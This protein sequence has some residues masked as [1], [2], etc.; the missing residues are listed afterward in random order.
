MGRNSLA[1][2]RRGKAP[3]GFEEK[4]FDDPEVK[5]GYLNYCRR[6]I[7]HF[8]PDYL[9]IGIEVNELRA[10][11]PERWPHLVELHRYVY[12]ELKKDHPDMQIFATLT[13]HNMLNEQHRNDERYQQDLKEFLKY[14][15]LAGISF[16]SFLGTIGNPERPKEA[17]EWL[18]DF[19]GDKPIAICETG[20]PAEPTDNPM[21]PQ[22]PGSLEAQKSYFET[23]FDY[24]MR[25]NYRF[26]V[27]FLHRDY[28]KMWEKLKE[29]RPA[30]QGAWKDIGLLDG[31]GSARPAWL[32][33]QECLSMELAG[34]EQDLCGVDME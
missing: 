16:Y 27:V 8:N 4:E 15:D 2:D 30:W 6:A 21:W 18:R 5:Q 20:F 19:V 31:E 11:S 10:N 17:F 29:T 24:A 1:V 13:L 23:L 25:D 32:L 14:N 33:W 12:D 28:D 22:W 7:E 3:E 34:P 26:I 9:A